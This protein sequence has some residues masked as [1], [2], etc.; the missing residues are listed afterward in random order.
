MQSS[1]HSFL[2]VS[3]TQ[4][5]APQMSYIN[6]LHVSKV[7]MHVLFMSSCKCYRLHILFCY[8]LHLDY[9]PALSLA[10]YKPDFS[11][12]LS[13]ST[14]SFQESCSLYPRCTSYFSVEHTV[15]PLTVVTNT[16]SGCT[17][18]YTISNLERCRTYHSTATALL[19][20]QR[21]YTVI[22]GDTVMLSE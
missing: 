5:I 18:V 1:T 9:Q 10:S 16:S 3:H 8:I 15:S 22:V 17:V 7:V 21:G 2:M 19:G 6:C 20:N 14:Y 13:T 12:R 4:Y 11:K